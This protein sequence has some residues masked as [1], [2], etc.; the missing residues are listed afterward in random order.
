M[1]QKGREVTPI[2]PE[3][4]KG[5]Y[6]QSVQTYVTEASGYPNHVCIAQN[7]ITR[8]CGMLFFVYSI[9]VCLDY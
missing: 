1:S 8:K 2:C 6:L 7:W 5:H 3:N 4:T 9:N